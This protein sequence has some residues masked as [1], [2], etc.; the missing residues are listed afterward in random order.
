MLRNIREE[1][2]PDY[3]GGFYLDEVVILRLAEFREKRAV[4]DLKRIA[5]FN[6]RLSPHP[7]SSGRHTRG[8]DS[9]GRITDMA[10][11]KN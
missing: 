11:E 1:P 10:N 5:A 8:C 9:G 4:D 3:P 2:K 7:I 6:V